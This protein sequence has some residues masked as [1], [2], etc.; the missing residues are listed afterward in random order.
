MVVLDLILILGGE[1]F[2]LQSP[3]AGSV[4]VELVVETL[5]RTSI[6]DQVIPEWCDGGV[7]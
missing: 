3:F 1:P 2:D 5:L 6:D 4:A 7:R